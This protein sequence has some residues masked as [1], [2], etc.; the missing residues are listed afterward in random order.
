VPAP[1]ASSLL[2]YAV[3]RAQF[4]PGRRK[5]RLA[6]ISRFE[7]VQMYFLFS[8]EAESAYLDQSLRQR[9]LNPRIMKRGLRGGEAGQFEV[10]PWDET[11]S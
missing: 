10:N 1:L 7:Q 3:A 11:R 6:E 5:V 4:F 9:D 8:L 2:V